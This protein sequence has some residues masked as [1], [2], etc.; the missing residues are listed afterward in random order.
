MI[1]QFQI[2]SIA[3]PCAPDF[4]RYTFYQ[5]HS[6]REHLVARARRPERPL[7]RAFETGQRPRV[8]RVVPV[9]IP[10]EL[11]IRICEVTLLKKHLP[12]STL[13]AR[14]RIKRNSSPFSRKTPRGTA[15]V[16][17]SGAPV[18]NTAA[19][20]TPWPPSAGDISPCHVYS[21]CTRLSRRTQPGQ[22][23]P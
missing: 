20:R 19:D 9:Q 10:G 2:K 17:G 1:Y 23:P 13:I 14:T 4:G 21:A 6:R 7:G 15:A 12:V 11:F 18:R 16:A 3:T 8:L 5:S 22:S